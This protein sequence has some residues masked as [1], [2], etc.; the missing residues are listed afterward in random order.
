MFSSLQTTVLIS[1]QGSLPYEEGLSL[2]QGFSGLLLIMEFL[3]QCVF[4][5]TPYPAIE[6]RYDAWQPRG[7]NYFKR[8]KG[9]K[10]NI[11]FFSGI[12]SFPTLIILAILGNFTSTVR[13][14]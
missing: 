9:L 14:L 11:I 10:Y 7:N 12:L 3:F 2:T 6:P 5:P 8:E 1:K 13:L 4:Q